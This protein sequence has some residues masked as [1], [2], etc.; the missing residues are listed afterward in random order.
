MQKRTRLIILLSAAA[1]LLW[2]A[3][4]VIVQNIRIKNLSGELGAQ[5]NLMLEET[6]EYRKNDDYFNQ[7]SRLLSLDLN[8][9]RASLGLPVS[10]Y[11][12]HEDE[13]KAATAAADGSRVYYD[14]VTVLLDAEAE[15][16]QSAF[17]G[18][19]LRSD[20]VA[21]FISEGGYE[22]RKMSNTRTDLFREGLFVA[23]VA[24]ESENEIKITDLSGNERRTTGPSNEILSFIEESAATA[25]EADEK[26]R[27]MKALV[28]G[29]ESDQKLAELCGD[30][31]E[32]SLSDDGALLVN[33]P[34]NSNSI[35]VDVNCGLE[36]EYRISGS[37]A[38]DS[39]DSMYGMLMEK[40]GSFDTRTAEEVLIDESKRKIEEIL[41]DEEY[42]GYLASLDLQL[43]PGIREDNDYIYYDLVH[44]DGSRLGSFSILKKL[45][46]IYLVDSDEVPV[47]SLK[48]IG[49]KKELGSRSS[50]KMI[51]PENIPAI[52]NLYNDGSSLSFLLVGTHE[53]NTDTMILVHADRTTGKA[54][55][56]GIPRDLYWKG[57]KINSIYQYFG[58]EQFK[59]ELS[60]ITGLDISNYIIVDMYAFID[61]INIM[62]G[63][64]VTLSEPLVDPTYRTRENG[65]W[66]TLNYSPGTYRL[67]GVEALRIARSRHGSND[68]DRS[69]RQQMIIESFLNRFREF[70][71]KDV[72]KVYG[73]IQALY[74]YVDTDFSLID[75]MNIYNSYGSAELA[76]KHVLSFDNIL[77]DTYSNT[78]MLDDE[79]E[80]PADYNKGA[81]I[82][83]PEGNDWNNIRW[84]VRRIINGE[85]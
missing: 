40:I 78:Y 28:A 64:D 68:F 7:M 84:Y 24:A 23:G 73:L 82:L 74:D 27:E 10:Q 67:N 26:F 83:L 53:K 37:A 51:I 12:V 9:T 4:S 43:A 29:L 47:S 70:S 65:Q 1:V 36:P 19:F 71:I 3:A 81:W 85:I 35:R 44:G 77:Y 79:L 32:I 50:R 17:L 22:C 58:P 5:K 69:K 56:I 6:T 62:G 8:Q 13:R 57:R 2:L 33:T 18:K 60:E 11:P 30:S 20:K 21:D 63:I 59:K 49:V 72:D 80:L 16:R 48:T 54:Y 45:G 14:S 55:M 52:D 38:G 76:G 39:F 15:N 66:S 25:A 31:L 61:I 41:G 46:D 34:L 75:M 42:I